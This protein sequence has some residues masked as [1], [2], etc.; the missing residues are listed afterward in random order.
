M[1][2]IIFL[3]VFSW[4]YNLNTEKNI[5]VKLLLNSYFWRNKNM[6]EKQDPSVSNKQKKEKKENNKSNKHSKKVNKKD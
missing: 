2:T 4:Y 6:S 5:K 1:R 3:L